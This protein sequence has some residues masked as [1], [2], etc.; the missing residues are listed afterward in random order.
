MKAGTNHGM[1]LRRVQKGKFTLSHQKYHSPQP[2]PLSLKLLLISFPNQ[3]TTKNNNPTPNNTLLTTK[4]T[5]PQRPKLQFPTP[6]ETPLLPEPFP[7]KSSP[8]LTTDSPFLLL[9]FSSP[10]SITYYAPK[11]KYPVTNPASRT[12]T[13]TKNTRPIAPVITTISAETHT[14]DEHI[15]YF[16]P[17]STKKPQTKAV[18]DMSQ[19]TE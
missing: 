8:T 2:H 7:H 14:S 3:K 17:F 9:L 15:R 5:L 13:A 6:S 19:S 12:S 18:A 10:P 1:Y 11:P 4:S 16:T